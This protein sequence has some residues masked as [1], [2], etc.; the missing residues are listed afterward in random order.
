MK[1]ITKK[2]KWLLLWVVC[3]THFSAYGQE[4]PAVTEK[5]EKKYGFVCY[6]DNNWYSVYR[7]DYEYGRKSAN[8][9]ACNQDG[10]EVVPCIYDNVSFHPEDKIKGWF[11]CELNGKKGAYDF[12]GQQIISCDYSEILYYN[13]Y[14]EVSKGVSIGK[15]PI[16]SWDVMGGP[17]G[18]F[19]SNGKV[20]IP[21]IYSNPYMIYQIS[22]NNTGYII[23]NKGGKTTTDHRVRGGKWGMV[24]MNNNVVIPFEYSAILQPTEGL[25]GVCKGGEGIYEPYLNAQLRYTGGKW[26]FFDIKSQKLA[27]PVEYDKVKAFSNGAAMVSKDGVSQL[28][29]NPIRGKKANI[30]GEGGITKS[31]IDENIPTANRID[32]NTFVFIFTV[33]QYSEDMTAIAAVNDGEIFREYCQKTL[34]IPNSNISYYENGTFAQFNAM[35]KRMKGINDAVDDDL[36]FIMYFSGL[37]YTDSHSTPYLLPSDVSMS[38]I[39]ATAYKLSDLCKDLSSLP[40]TLLIIDAPFDGNDRSGKN[41]TA[42]RGIAIKAKVPELYGNIVMFLGA[43]DTG[44]ARVNSEKNH[45]LMTY[46]LLKKL[47]ET[48]GRILL[49]DL[50][51]STI[52]DVTRNSIKLSTNG[53]V[54]KPQLKVSEN[55]K[56]VNEKVKK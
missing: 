3:I 29:N 23:V 51:V 9:G 37:G 21:C 28:V 55:C 49:R 15:D 13:G 18:V 10:V 7:G 52:S 5:L 25:S 48:K 47:R 6:H 19:D 30:V 35:T 40:A 44:I 11:K 32:E 17:F 56:I 16:S 54:Q 53:F 38:N 46:S 36:R 1:A 4:N 27:I 50:F 34:G 39:D 12:N 45:G 2:K 41:I 26:G 24:D 22:Y 42:G 33:E 20:I 31:D 14:F 8:A 43:S